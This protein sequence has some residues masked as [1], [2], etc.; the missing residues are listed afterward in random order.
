MKTSPAS[1]S[2]IYSF[3]AIGERLGTAGQPTEAQFRT[4][5]ETGF[6]VVINLALPTSDN[7]LAHEG[8]IVT[9][10]GM[11]YVHIPVDF[12]APTTADF[13]AFCRVIAAFEGRRVFVHCAANKRVSAFVFLHRVLYG[14]VGMA[15]AERDLHAIWQPDEVWSRFIRNQ[16]ESGGD[17]P[18]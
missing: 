17:D 5:R 6:E 3:R 13:R 7:A 14:R 9:G 15:D 12:E 10:L 2:E 16:L 11:S 18:A 1:L 8:S 4:V